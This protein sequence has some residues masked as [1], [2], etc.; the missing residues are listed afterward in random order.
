MAA[1]QQRRHVSTAHAAGLSES[2]DA[3]ACEATTSDLAADDDAV[4]LFASQATAWSVVQHPRSQRT[5]SF[6]SHASAR[7]LTTT[8]SGGGQSGAGEASC[9][10]HASSLGSP[11][12]LRQA[13]LLPAH[14]GDG[15]FF[16]AP[17]SVGP[18]D[19]DEEETTARQAARDGALFSSVYA[20]LHDSSDDG[21]ARSSAFSAYS[22]IEPPRQVAGAS[23]PASTSDSSEW[24]LT[25]AALSTIPS[26]PPVLRAARQRHQL[27][28]DDEESAELTSDSGGEE[29]AQAHSGARSQRQVIATDRS[30]LEVS[31]AT[32]RG[33]QDEQDEQDWAQSPHALSAGLFGPARRSRRPPPRS[34]AQELHP[35]TVLLPIGISPGNT[36]ASSVRSR[37]SS[38]SAGG[39]SHGFKRRHRHS[40]TGRSASSQKRSAH[41][42]LKADPALGASLSGQAQVLEEIAREE[43]ERARRMTA[44][45]EERREQVRVRDAEAKILFG[46]SSPP[47]GSGTQAS[48]DL[49]P[50]DEARVAFWAARRSRRPELHVHRPGDARALERAP[51]GFARR[52]RSH[53]DPFPCADP[54]P[55]Q[56]RL[57]RR[58]GL[59]RPCRG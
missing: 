31:E 20:D 53:P 8:T 59:C 32:K 27:R 16:G 37:R 1:F 25:E 38:S 44:I 5:Q 58:T 7:S 33:A 9:E 57:P 54:R 10:D 13:A 42:V 40:G 49:R 26:R 4:L 24:P 23:L 51:P 39:H 15:V 3:S 21:I 30:A 17:G 36:P 12:S 52:R 50:T 18:S 46:Q 6:T 35:T 28:D 19:V 34:V 14:S 43:E 47:A 41:A 11:A 2:S 55:G 22:H 56:T 45:L 48:L 29:G